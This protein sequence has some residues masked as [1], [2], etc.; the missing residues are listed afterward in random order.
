MEGVAVPPERDN[1]SNLR[2]RP[3]GEWNEER[4]G[5]GGPLG[6]AQGFQVQAARA[7]RAYGN[8][9]SYLTSLDLA[10]ELVEP[11]AKPCDFGLTP[12]L[13]NF[14]SGALSALARPSASLGLNRA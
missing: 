7:T 2:L 13:D 14:F 4:P 3:L 1:D 5:R 9:N 12:L 10:G 11:F 8:N 6:R